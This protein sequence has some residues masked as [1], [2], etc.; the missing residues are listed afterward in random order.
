M[1]NYLNR[2]RIAIV[3][4][5]A[6]FA[7]LVFVVITWGLGFS[8]WYGC[9]KPSNTVEKAIVQCALGMAGFVVLGVLFNLLHIP[10]DWKLFTLAAILGPITYAIIKR[11]HLKLPK[12][13]INKSTLYL[14]IVIILFLITLNMHLKGAFSYPYLEDTDPWEHALSVKYI[15]QEKSLKASEDVTKSYFSYLAPYPPGYDLTMGV[16]H[17]LNPS[18]TSTLKT[19]NAII[20]SFIILLFYIFAKS[21][22]GNRDKALVATFI[23]AMIPSF[24]SHFIWAHSLVIFLLFPMLIAFEFL[25]KDKRWQLPAAII[26]AAILTSQPAQPVKIAVMLGIYIVI[27]SRSEERR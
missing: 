13:K 21:F 18:I 4:N 10:Q 5:M 27:K 7:I 8:A 6:L 17:Q 26:F 14:A 22:I 19:F 20:I 2:F 23:F 25:N 9:K 3:G 1:D 11:K 24:L 15:T 12:L 16:L